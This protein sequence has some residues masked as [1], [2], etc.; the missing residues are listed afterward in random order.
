MFM[1]MQA[2]LWNL[3]LIFI[4]NSV[5]SEP[6]TP[7]TQ[8]LFIATMA[9]FSLAATWEN[10]VVEPP[11]EMEDLE[12]LSSFEIISEEEISR[13]DRP[14]HNFSSS[15]STST[16]SGSG[17]SRP[18]SVTSI[19]SMIS[20]GSSLSLGSMSVSSHSSVSSNGSSFWSHFRRDGSEKAQEEKPKPKAARSFTKPEPASQ[21]ARKTALPELT[22]EELESSTSRI[23]FIIQLQG[24]YNHGIDKTQNFQEI[25]DQERQTED[26]SAKSKT[27]WFFSSI[28]DIPDRIRKAKADKN[29]F[30]VDNL[31]DSMREELKNIYVY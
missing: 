27:S 16:S 1:E 3:D 20:K 6:V 30:N 2:P 14:F 7:T 9:T 18:P 11:E 17:T 31:S 26:S 29:R 24:H 15:S 25:L 19:S 13:L 22:E 12:F 23:W 4:P 5:I 8:R 28:K 21:P 10:E